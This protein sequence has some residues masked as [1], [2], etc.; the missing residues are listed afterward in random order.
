VDVHVIFA[1]LH[2]FNLMEQSPFDAA[3]VSLIDQ[4]LQRQMQPLCLIAHN[5]WNFDFPILKAMIISSG[6]KLCT[7]I[8]CADSLTAFCN[9]IKIA[10][11]VR[12]HQ[13]VENTSTTQMTAT[14]KQNEQDSGLSDALAAHDKNKCLTQTTAKKKAS[15]QL[16][17]VYKAYFG[18]TIMNAHSAEGDCLA[19]VQIFNREFEELS[20]WI[21]QHAIDFSEINPQ[22][23]APLLFLPENS[24][25]TGKNVREILGPATDPKVEIDE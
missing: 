5:G 11:K 12:R 18:E 19:L 6:Q 25:G 21:D 4:F 3:T 8:L 20:K 2:N 15:F 1:G 22:Y 9:I 7:Q 14:T 10:E 17:A 23:Q 13:G 16:A 24:S